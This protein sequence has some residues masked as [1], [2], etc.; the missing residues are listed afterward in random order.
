MRAGLAALGLKL[1]TAPES[2]A[3]T[4]SVVFLPTGVDDAAFRKGV[5]ARGVVI[6]GCLGP[7]AGK[8]FRIG[9]MGNIGPGEVAK[10][11]QAIEE[12]LRDL[13]VAVAPGAAVAA[14]AGPLVARETPK[15]HLV[16]A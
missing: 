16:P 11:L 7:L 3:D 5:A 13:G 12:S 2:R 9:H 1:V 4:L 8:A 6:A 15:E 14:A 10:T